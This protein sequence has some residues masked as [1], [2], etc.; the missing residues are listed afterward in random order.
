MLEDIFEKELPSLHG[1]E[2]KIFEEKSSYV[3]FRTGRYYDNLDYEIYK[4]K[5]LLKSLPGTPFKEKVQYFFKT[6]KMRYNLHKLKKARK[7]NPNI[8]YMDL[9]DILK[10]FK[11]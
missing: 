7:K 11:A 9:S 3:R 1:V 5:V 10:Q 4:T 6:L 8:L 2:R